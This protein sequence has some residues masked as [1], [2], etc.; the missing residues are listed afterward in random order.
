M[1]TALSIRLTRVAL[2]LL[3]LSSCSNRS[4]SENAGDTAPVP[5]RTENAASTPWIV[6]GPFDFGWDPATGRG[7]I[8]QRFD[9]GD[10]A[11]IC[12]QC[13]FPGYTGGLVIGNYNGSGFEWIPSVPIRGYHSLNIFC[14]QDESIWD[15][16]SNKEYTFGWSE[17]FGTG[18]DGERL[19][20]VSGAIEE[21]V[22]E[23]V[24]LRS[25]NR[26]GCYEVDK[27]L[28]WKQGATYVLIGT[29]VWN[30]CNNAVQFD[31]WT[32]DD[33]WIGKYR[34]S[35]GDIG[36]ANGMLVRFEAK[37]ESTTFQF[38]G[39]YDLGNIE[40]GERE[41]TFTGAANFMMPRPRLNMGG[42]G[43]PEAPFASNSTF[44]QPDNVYIA[45]RFAHAD[46]EI[47]PQR[48]LD[49]KG[50]LAINLG[51]KSV[52]LA[53]Q[54]TVSFGY[55]LG[56]AQSTG[57]AEVPLAPKINAKEWTYL[58]GWSGPLDLVRFDS[59]MIELRLTETALDVVGTYVFANN[60]PETQRFGVSYPLPVDS[61][62]PMPER[63]E[64]DGRRLSSLSASGAWF[65][66]DVP[67]HG[68]RTFRI[69]YRQRHLNRA[70]TYIVTSAATW[71]HPIR[72]AV[73]VVRYPKD[74][75][76]VTI[77]YPADSVKNV[78]EEVEY[79]FGRD[80]FRPAEDV[81][82]RWR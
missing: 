22:A 65:P 81:V 35:E 31:F 60:G 49:N 53:P 51:W 69:H 56:M 63:I 16:S 44:P 32:G 50:M 9:S 21:L 2:A 41:G 28:I 8:R 52:S 5:S 43:S 59:E 71:R 57:T 77:S 39:V 47:R 54:E 23:R 79:R 12:L 4:R 30:I 72:R 62:H 58:D 3:I 78:G 64:L 26:G 13:G 68:T 11:Q 19:E 42:R 20:Y 55:A 27:R 1:C 17:N 14:A 15:R 82:V 61:M 18:E 10:V 75:H 7:S 80:D 67:A 76:D 73:F 74:F 6:S 33:P 66:I 38:G 46:S 45:N 29:R 48:P 40:S 70:A 36:Y 25:K 37:L 24:V 34:S